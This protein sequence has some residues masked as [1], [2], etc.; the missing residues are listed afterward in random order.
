MTQHNK[1][2]HKGDTV[3]WAWGQGQGH[4]TIREVQDKTVTRT[5]KG[6]SITRHGTPENPALWIA[7]DNDSHVLK[8]ASEVE[9]Q[10]R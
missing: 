7:T 5:I 3:H 8:L 9:W 6:H 1:G 10:E 4:G 2:F